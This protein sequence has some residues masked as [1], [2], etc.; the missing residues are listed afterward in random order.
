MTK[1]IVSITI[2]PEVGSPVTRYVLNFTP[3]TINVTAQQNR[4]MN[5][6]NNQFAEACIKTFN[7]DKY[8]AKVIEVES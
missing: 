1:T 6:M 3:L 2:K 7:L 8:D 5:L 4:A